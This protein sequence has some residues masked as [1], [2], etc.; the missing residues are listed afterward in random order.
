MAGEGGYSH[1]S[2]DTSPPR[3]PTHPTSWHPRR[4]K[5]THD[6]SRWR[7]REMLNTDRVRILSGGGGGGGQY[8][9]FPKC[10]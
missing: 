10:G 6:C 2:D 9:K 3:A 5:R 7:A 4:T 8:Y 1:A